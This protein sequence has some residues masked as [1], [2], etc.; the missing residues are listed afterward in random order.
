MPST[1][2][3][4]TVGT[5]GLQKGLLSRS[6]QVRRN[7]SLV[8]PGD[9]FLLPQAPLDWFHTGL[10]IEV[11]GDVFVTIEGNTNEDGSRNGVGVFKRNRNFKKSSIDVFSIRP[12]V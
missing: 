2:S 11:K 3:C 12:L 9:I 1:H 8:K 7:P 4:D 10:V 6:A 5:T